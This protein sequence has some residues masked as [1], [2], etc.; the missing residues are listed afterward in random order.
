MTVGLDCMCCAAVLCVVRV[1]GLSG[2]T[3]R[4]ICR[5]SIQ[6][7]AT[8]GRS[9]VPRATTPSDDVGVK[10]IILRT[11]GAGNGPDKNEDFLR[12]L[13]EAN[14]SGVVIV[15][16]TQCQRRSR[17]VEGLEVIVRTAW[18]P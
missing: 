12:A 7:A 10:G 3:I 2:T 16:T 11:F 17:R 13:K 18:V 5:A 4:E 15:S 9:A 6:R 14:D 1:P 8:K